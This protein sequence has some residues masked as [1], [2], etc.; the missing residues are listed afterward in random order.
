MRRDLTIAGGGYLVFVALTELARRRSRRSSLATLSAML[1]VDGVYLGFT[2][3]I[4]GGTQSPLWFMLF[5]HLVA[6]T[7]LASY[8]TGL[9]IALWHS[10]VTIVVLYAQAAELIPPH[11]SAPGVVPEPG[12]GLGSLPVFNITAFWIVAIVTAAFSSLN[13]RELRRRRADSEALA[14]MAT[15][16]E[17]LQRPADIAE[18]LLD[19][20][21]EGFGFGRGV[22][23]AAAD[24][25]TVLAARGAGELAPAPATLDRVVSE[26]WTRRQP[27][28]VK[29]LD[30]EANP[31][32]GGAA[33]AIPQAC[34]CCRSTRRASCSA[35]WRSST[36][37]G[38]AGRSSGGSS[39]SPPSSSHT[40]ALALRNARLLEQ[41]QRT[42]DT[43]GLTGVA[44]RR[45]LDVT[46]AR[47][48][49]RARRDSGSVSLLLIDVDHFKDFND[50]HGHLAGD[51]AL[52]AVARA[53]E[54]AN[55]GFDLVARYGGE[56]FAV[57]LPGCAADESL[58]VAERLRQ[59]VRELA[60]AE[61]IT[62]S[63]GASSFPDDG[64]A[65]G[66]AAQG[67]GR[68]ALFVQARRARPCRAVRSSGI[69][70]GCELAALAAGRPAPPRPRTA[71]QASRAAHRSRAPRRRPRRRTG[72]AARA[73]IVTS[74]ATPAIAP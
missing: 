8:R 6:V 23:L 2:T 22:V 3:Y 38:A 5:V 12:S 74:A 57:V 15:E 67:R 63:V 52:Q 48:L 44:N 37:R 7:L 11:E 26:A 25:V 4:T 43:D 51:D 21:G 50:R 54:Q 24:G 42:A 56:E 19:W 71:P 40:P 9:K 64:A 62:V 29:E 45:M 27:M 34:S 61:P 16:M 59:V 65:C 28:L 58:Q 1:L 30:P 36:A 73:S 18:K 46:L 60:L 72:T 14:T 20:L 31:T 17:D 69:G 32:L 70:C 49:V 55:R 10:L 13:E 33:A 66:C 53:L 39:R 35:R 47:E 41:I 68:G